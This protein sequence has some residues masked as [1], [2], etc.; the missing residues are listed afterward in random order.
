MTLLVISGLKYP[1]PAAIAG[2]AWQVSR[3]MYA[4]GYVY[5]TKEN[6][7]GRYNGVWGYG[8]LVGLIGMSIW[9]SVS[10]VMET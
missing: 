5:S 10:M 9:T 4:N 2:V 8:P 3:V 7:A 1:V 6:G